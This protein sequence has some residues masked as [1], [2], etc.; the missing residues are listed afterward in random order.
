MMPSQIMAASKSNIIGIATRNSERGSGGENAAP[1]T[2]VV[3]QMC[4]R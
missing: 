4:R 2:N 3:N 1:S